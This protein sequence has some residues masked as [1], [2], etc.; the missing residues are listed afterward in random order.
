[1]EA[2]S[3]WRYASGFSRIWLPFLDTYRTMCL[4][5]QPEFQRLLEQAG[6]LPIA[7][8]APCAV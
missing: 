7:A 1:M 4:A 2:K 6:E 5:P 8:W 3:R